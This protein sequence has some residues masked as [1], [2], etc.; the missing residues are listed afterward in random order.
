M[1]LT[2]AVGRPT[3]AD[4][5]FSRKLVTDIVLVAAGT[6]LT[7][8][9]AQVLIPLWPVPITGQTFA[10][11]FVGATLGAVR[12]AISMALYLVLGVVGLPIF[13]EGGSGS[14]IGSTSGGFVV[15]FVF[16]A[17]LV[18]WLAQ[19]EWDR[20]VLGTLVAFAAGT[21][22]IYAF[23]LPWLYAVLTTF[24]ADVMT[25]YFGTTNVLQAT[26]TGG[27]LPFLVGDA[28]KAL[29]AA[30]ILPLAWKLIT[31]A[32]AAKTEL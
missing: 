7:S 8:L 20:K 30:G 13:A 21:V 9:M 14:L 16:A 19:R 27:I 23:G 4:R 10:V 15:G 11:L 32:D 6:A 3:L 18:G 1:T 24:P 12:G 2:L 26:F 25:T 29:L 17:A 31:R 28:L 5:V 22:V